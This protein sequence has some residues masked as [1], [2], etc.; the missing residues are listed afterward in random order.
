MKVI[1]GKHCSLF[2][3][4]LRSICLA[5]ILL[6]ALTACRT[7]AEAAA[8]AGN[9]VQQRIARSYG[10][11]PLSFEQN[12]GQAD[13][14]VR[15]LS[16][17]KGYAISFGAD[18][19]DFLLSKASHEAGIPSPAELHRK[20]KS[21]DGTVRSDLL[22]LRLVS[23]TTPAVSGENQ[24][25][26]TVNYFIGNDPAKW[27]AGI[28]TFERVR[29]TS[30]YP[31]INLVYYGS[32]GRVEFD[33]EL[34][35]GADPKVI[36]FRLDGSR[37]LKVDR[38]GNLVVIA[39]SGSVS[40]RKP[41]VYQPAD[42]LTANNGKHLVAGSFRVCADHTVRFAL[43]HYDHTKPLIID[44]ILNYSTYLGQGSAA[45]AL[46]VD[47]A[48]E[49]Y[50]TGWA[51]KGF[52]T[53]ANGFQA[54]QE[55]PHFGTITPY[56]AKFNS[57]GTA[58]LYSTY[59]S[60]TGNDIAN[61]IALDAAGN[62]YVAGAATSTDFPITPGA[63]QTTNKATSAT[64]KDTGFVAVLNSAG[65]GL[66]YSTYLGGST[67]SGVMSI[68]V[69]SSANAYVTGFTYDTD[70]PITA[71]AYQIAP[72][73]K[74]AAD[75]YSGFVSKLNSAG[76]GLLYST[77]LSGA[78][79]DSAQAIALDPAGDAYVTG[80]TY[81]LDFPITPGAFQQTNNAL[82]GTAF[83]TEIN[84]SGTGLAY[85]TYLGGS[86]SEE[87]LAIAVDASGSAYVTGNTSSASFPVTPGVF[88]PTLK[89]NH[90]LSTN[91]F[92]TKFNSGG[93]A[94]IY[95]TFL[96][97]SNNGYGGGSA[98][99]GTGI[100]VDAQGN[101]T[102]AGD[103]AGLDFPVTTGAFQTQNLAE[104]NSADPATFLTRI[105]PIA[106]AL[107]YS[108]FLSGSGDQTGYTCDCA[109]GLAV[110]PSGNVYLA[111]V[112]VS[113]DFPTTSGAFQTPFQTDEYQTFV[114]EFNS[115]EMKTLPPT[116]VIITSSAGSVEYGQPVTFT[117]TVQSTSGDTPTGIVGF[118]FPGHEISDASGN[119]MG[120]WTTVGMNGSGAA[121]F[122]TSS[123]IPQL[124]NINAYYLGD[125]NNAPSN[126]TFAQTVTTIPT[127][128]TLTSSANPA[129]YGTPVT[130]TATVLDN[131]GK[132]AKGWV[133]F[134]F[135]TTGYAEVDLDSAG[136]ASWV[137]GTG[138]A[139]LP[140][141]ADTVNAE[142]MPYTG[143]QQTSSALTETFTALGTAPAPTF[144]PP[145]GTYTS[146]QQIVLADTMSAA[147]IYY[148]TDGST[149]VAGS[150]SPFQPGVPVQ[151]SS[152]ETIQAIAVVTGYTTSAIASA[153][154][155][156]H[157]PPPD[158]SM[159]LTP[160]SMTVSAG[161]PASATV[162]MSAL[163]GFTQAISLSCSGQ[164]AGVTCSFAPASITS[165]STSVLTISA[166]SSSIAAR[167]SAA[168]A[169]IPFVLL[170]MATGWIKRMRRSRWTLLFACI[171]LIVLNG[172][173][174]GGTGSTQSPTPVATTST[175]MVTGTSGSLS[176]SAQLTL[177]LN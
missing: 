14:R 156:I 65:T 45:K 64:G 8:P 24:L 84:P 39:L 26:G 56:V 30:V 38:E 146:V 110:D 6:F 12:Q 27:H 118:N 176:H 36:R 149:P 123:L 162:G 70:F 78:S 85:S 144:A 113:V 103:T 127:S 32:R 77:Y 124:G 154:Y 33:F 10:T 131:T 168:S 157:L 173:G 40:F 170:A 34:A 37:A 75:A 60:G 13:P 49:V 139:P 1:A 16:Q 160:P 20:V 141:G 73:K 94:L 120:P 19:A 117:A 42:P 21:Q 152:S 50:V 142:F 79:L 89:T 87:A 55:N 90:G 67:Q 138:G 43:G 132:P 115:S 107:L 140:V 57:T 5:L 62:A 100:A 29:Y 48:G 82:N 151:V 114:T 106:T 59:L 163:N 174:G 153:A 128:T 165:G 167:R 96:G 159:S 76:T 51:D 44:P 93:T 105:N 7:L 66:I 52:P 133:L 54:S 130:F 71:G 88:Q 134:A 135:D 104:L 125:A 169:F 121:I 2:L 46:A 9:A 108:T 101:A 111:G 61:A 98:D 172:C 18:G 47:S 35:A 126:A 11:L 122:T 147:A 81:S 17:G 15:F 148:T 177:T 166:P 137:N 136:Q 129:A 155:V 63:L 86:F 92:I 31:G 158:F 22:R 97:G 161:Q 143:Y 74:Q 164:P 150:S 175:V 28:P 99:Y 83:V 3:R 95:S 171:G 119:G 145:A 72:V 58:L 116:N 68:A 80:Y 41:V 109:V 112:T 53:T 25:P 102:V 69:D 4:P 91:S 23:G